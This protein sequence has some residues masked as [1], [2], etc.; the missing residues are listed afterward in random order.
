MQ[1]SNMIL[2]LC[3]FAPILSFASLVI[4]NET[5]DTIDVIIE[6][7]CNPLEA[8][9]TDDPISGH[10]SMSIDIDEKIQSVCLLLKNTQSHL[11]SEK[12]THPNQCGVTLY[13]EKTQTLHLEMQKGCT[14]R[15]D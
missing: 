4:H 3:L 8:R 12:I 10:D 5:P 11:L 14:E 7:H 9:T 2:F 13:E 6:D 15:I 1:K